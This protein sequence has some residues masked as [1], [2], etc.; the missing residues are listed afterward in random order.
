MGTK[1]FTLCNGHFEI[2]NSDLKKLHI[3]REDIVKIIYLA[4]DK[5]FG[6]DYSRME[7]FDT[8]EEALAELKK[9]RS[10]LRETQLT[11][12]RGYTGDV[13]AVVEEE[14]TDD[15]E[16]EDFGSWWYADFDL[17]EK[18]EDGEDCDE[19]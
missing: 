10:D 8:E 19:L 9:H 16:C 17:P 2:T 1:K 6:D 3:G 13:W 11:L 12:G 15:G 5:A 14:F 4:T 7:E 18:E